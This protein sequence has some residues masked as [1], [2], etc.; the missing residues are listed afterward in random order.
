MTKKKQPHQRIRN[1]F[2]PALLKRKPS[3]YK[4]KRRRKKP[5]HKENYDESS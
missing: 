4:D 3:R 2:I 5:K 1:P